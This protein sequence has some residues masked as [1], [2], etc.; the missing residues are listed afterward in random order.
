MLQQP[1][2]Q[3][4][5]EP[6]FGR[7]IPVSSFEEL[8]PAF[9]RFQGRMEQTSQGRFN[10]TIRFAIGRSVRVMQIDGNQSLRAQGRDD[11]GMFS[12]F[13]EADEESA[14]M[15]QGRQVTHGQVSACGVDTEMDH[16]TGRHLRC[17]GVFVSPLQLQDAARA[18]LNTD[19]VNVSR[20]WTLVSP[21]PE[22]YR[23]LQRQL[24]RLL[25]LGAADPSILTTPE[26]SQ[27]E[28]L[29]IRALV[30]A[31]HSGT[32]PQRIPACP[33]GHGFSTA[34]RKSCVPDFANP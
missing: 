32:P 26:G 17:L 4:P 13:F 11:S 33:S 1:E 22:V 29:C 3:R 12:A 5:P 34:P 19:E 6:V 20:T 16:F 15:W 18:L 14:S 8:G 23:D 25:D 31:L 27:L 2:P 24:A 21:P 28:E 7:S 9:G 10:G 30:A